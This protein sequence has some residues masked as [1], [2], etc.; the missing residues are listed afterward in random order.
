MNIL[1]TEEERTVLL[2][3]IENAEQV[4]IRGVDHADSRAFKDMLRDR[5]QVLE[6]VKQKIQCDLA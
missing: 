2:D 6:S 3:L 1:V 4:I 5:L